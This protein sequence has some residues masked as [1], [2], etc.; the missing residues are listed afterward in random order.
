MA[1]LDTLYSV[2][3]DV[4][5][6]MV[7]VTSQE[8]FEKELQVIKSIFKDSINHFIKKNYGYGATDAHTHGVISDMEISAKYL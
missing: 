4:Y 3:Y 6:D 1:D 7:A 8:K 2:I 5:P